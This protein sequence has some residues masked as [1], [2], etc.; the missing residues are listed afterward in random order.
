MSLRRCSIV[1][2]VDVGSTSCGLSDGRICGGLKLRG[3]GEDGGMVCGVVFAG[4]VSDGVGVGSSSIMAG[5][6]TGA[7]GFWVCEWRIL[8]P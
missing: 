1:I 8:G 4:G 3:S 2:V 5:V 6:A 7:L